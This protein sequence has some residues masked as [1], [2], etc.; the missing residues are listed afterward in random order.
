[1]AYGYRPAFGSYPSR[2]DE[3]QGRRSLPTVS[4]LTGRGWSTGAPLATLRIHREI[5][6]VADYLVT[7]SLSGSGTRSQTR[8]VNDSV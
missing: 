1:L 5:R 3:T 6:L 4:T 8:I 7:T 2:E